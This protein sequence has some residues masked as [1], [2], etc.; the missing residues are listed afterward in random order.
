MDSEDGENK[1]SS[2]TQGAYNPA[3]GMKETYSASKRG[4]K[5]CAG[6]QLEKIASLASLLCI[7][8]THIDTVLF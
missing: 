4:S 8:I 1:S 6:S 3:E 7:S 5:W 2:Y